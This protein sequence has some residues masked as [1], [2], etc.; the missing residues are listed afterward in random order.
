M[1]KAIDKKAPKEKVA[2]TVAPDILKSYIGKYQLQP[3]FVIEVSVK[4][5]QIF[6]V[7]TGQPQF[8][9]FAETETTFFLK[10]VP[11]S[12]DFNKNDKGDVI[13]LTLHQG[14]QD[15]EGKKIE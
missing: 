13:S 7:A 10:V 6:A 2:I 8:E 11:A 9:L 14:G 3:G 1:E 15:V 4:G 12:V 5:N